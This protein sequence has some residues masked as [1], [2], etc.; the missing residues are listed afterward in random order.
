LSGRLT[1]DEYD[2]HA[3]AAGLV[4]AARWSTW[5]RV[6]FTATSDYVVA[7]HSLASKR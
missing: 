3:T 5:D 2:T 6:P 4:D 1:I 7:V